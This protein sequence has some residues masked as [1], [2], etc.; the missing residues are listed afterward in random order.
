MCDNQPGNWELAGDEGGANWTFGLNDYELD[1]MGSLDK[2]PLPFT[3]RKMCWRSLWDLDL[4]LE[5]IEG[6]EV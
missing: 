2:D 4:D 5:K 3:V 1:L 6:R